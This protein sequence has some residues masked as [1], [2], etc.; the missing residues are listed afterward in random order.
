MTR[1][2][3]NRAE[4]EPFRLVF[5]HDQLTADT[6][7]KIYK[8]AAERDLEIT[9]VQ[10]LNP[11]GLAADPTNAFLA[12]VR[13]AAVV[14]ASLFNTDNDDVP[15]GA[16]LAADTFIEGTLSATLA[17]RWVEGGEELSLFFD[18]DG[19]ATLPPGHLVV[20]GYLY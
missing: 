18:E 17:D 8:V 15:A 20:E 19:A 4:A 2:P 6:T 16:A 5:P 1:R 12:Q 14:V 3:F 13:Q 10:Y 11:T 9:R 7:L